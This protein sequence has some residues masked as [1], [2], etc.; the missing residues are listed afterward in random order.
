M[1]GGYFD[2]QQYHI[3]DIVDKIEQV[4]SQ[5]NIPD[6]D[7]YTYDY[8]EE[9]IKQ[10]KDAV[11]ILNIGKIM[12]HRIDWLLSSDDGEESFHIRLQEDF[13]KLRDSHDAKD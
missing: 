4:I 9:T 1:S 10:F 13:N 6:E 5:N 3:N 11:D 8:S 12:A 2:Y 7:G